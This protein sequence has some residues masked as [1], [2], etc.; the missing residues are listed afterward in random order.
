MGHMHKKDSES[1]RGKDAIR[2]IVI[3]QAGGIQ[4]I[5]NEFFSAI[6]LARQSVQ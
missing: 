6:Y 1:F 4:F 2:A 5:Q 3:V